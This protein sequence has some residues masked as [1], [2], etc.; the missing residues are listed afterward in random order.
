MS[1]VR[2]TNEEAFEPTG[3]PGYTIQMLAYPE[4]ATF[5]NSRVAAGGH[6]PMLGQGGIGELLHQIADVLINLRAR[7][8]SRAGA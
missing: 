2:V 3:F 6:A 4:A 8:H 5:I 7:R 1:F